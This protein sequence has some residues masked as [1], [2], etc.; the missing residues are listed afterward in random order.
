MQQSDAEGVDFKPFFDLIIGVLFIFLIL[1]AAQM[2]FT[3]WAPIREEA[4][5]WQNDTSAFLEELAGALRRVGITSSVDTNTTTLAV[6][7]RELVAAPRD[8]RPRILT[9]P[10]ADFGR[11]LDAHLS[12]VARP[13]PPQATCPA[14]PLLEL[15]HVVGEV[16]LTAMPSGTELA[17]DRYAKLVAIELAAGIFHATPHLL[18]LTGSNGASIIDVSSVIAAV[19]GRDGL[20]GDVVLRFRFEPPRGN[21]NSP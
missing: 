18:A 14:V 7:L 9:G 17:Q 10:A 15:R 21:D 5:S 19:P 20:E 4:R 6:P 11:V 1:I 16:R 3:Q 12:C 8:G 2:F 13:V